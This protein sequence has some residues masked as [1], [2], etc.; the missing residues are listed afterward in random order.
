MRV[1]C[2]AQICAATL[3]A[4]DQSL[5]T[6]KRDDELAGDTI[7][8]ELCAGQHSNRIRLSPSFVVMIKPFWTISRPQIAISPSRGSKVS[9]DGFAVEGFT[10]TAPKQPLLVEANLK[11]TSGHRSGCAPPRAADRFPFTIGR[12]QFRSCEE[13]HL[14]HSFGFTQVVRD[15]D[16]LL[17]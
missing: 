16:S 5:F 17:A 15:H 11:I 6:E 8:V 1:R 3:H 2:E 10:M 4:D 13:L 12:E 7:L 9:V 14:A